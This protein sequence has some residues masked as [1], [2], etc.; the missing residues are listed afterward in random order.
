[1]SELEA[2]LKDKMGYSTGTCKTCFHFG[3]TENGKLKSKCRLNPACQF[4]VKV[5]ASCNM[6]QPKF[7]GSK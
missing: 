4:T 6:Y 1:M 5:N 3:V 7:V 2:I